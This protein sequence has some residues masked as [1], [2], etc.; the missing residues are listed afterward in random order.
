VKKYMKRII[1]V[2]VV[3]ALMV[4]L[5][6]ST[7]VSPAFAT[8]TDN[9]KDHFGYGKIKDYQYSGKPEVKHVYGWACGSKNVA[10]YNDLCQD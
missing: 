2:L 4:V 10:G 9:N 8:H 7:A 6:A 3:S 1:K 5:M